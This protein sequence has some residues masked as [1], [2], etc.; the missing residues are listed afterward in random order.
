M[1]SYILIIYIPIILTILKKNK[2]GLK[3]ALFFLILISSLRYEFG[4]DYTS[5]YSIFNNIKDNNMSIYIQ[6]LEKGYVYLNRIIAFFNLD[7]MWIFFIITSLNLF[8]IYKILIWLKINPKYYWL[9]LFLYLINYNYYFYHLSMVRQS[10][11]IYLFTFSLKYLYEKNFF[12]FSL[13]IILGSFFHKSIIIFIFIYHI[14]KYINRKLMILLVILGL[15]IGLNQGF[16]V[17]F[18]KIILNVLGLEGYSHYIRVSELNTGLGYILKIFISI[19]LIILLELK[20]IALKEKLILKLYFFYYFFSFFSIYMGPTYH[21]FLCYFDWI[22][23]LSFYL[24]LKILF[25]NLKEVRKYKKII[26]FIIVIFFNL[27]FIKKYENMIEKY[28]KTNY[29]NFVSKYKCI[30]F[31]NDRYKG[32]N[33]YR[34][35]KTG[36]IYFY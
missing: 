17:S 6:E 5:Y 31:Y 8:L 32:K 24:I 23:I 29:I 27:L 11:A 22:K 13:L 4:A 16:T 21:R 3:L 36:E 20:N 7:F 18:L 10:V 34:D 30:L 12:K 19:S 28:K 9:I 33:F 14:I 25:S 35:R 15:F 26:I 2:L 1:T